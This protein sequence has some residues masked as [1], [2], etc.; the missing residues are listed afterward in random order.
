MKWALV[1]TAEGVVA[2]YSDDDSLYDLGVT[3]GMVFYLSGS[4]D[5]AFSQ[6]LSAACDEGPLAGEAPRAP[7]EMPKRPKD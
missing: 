7:S 5:P 4:Q 3:D 1:K 2:S 6:G